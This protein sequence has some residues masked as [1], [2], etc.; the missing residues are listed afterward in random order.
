[1][2]KKAGK[3][4]QINR[5]NK[6]RRNVRN[7]KNT[8]KQKRRTNKQ[9]RKKRATRKRHGVKRGGSAAAEEPASAAAEEPA[10]AAAEEPVDYMIPS[11]RLVLPV[12][13]IEGPIGEEEL[14]LDRAADYISKNEPGM[15]ALCFLQFTDIVKPN[16]IYRDVA[17]LLDV[18]TSAL[19]VFNQRKVVNAKGNI[20]ASKPKQT[21]L[22]ELQNSD[23]R[24]TQIDEGKQLWQV[25]IDKYLQQFYDVHKVLH[26]AARSYSELEN[27][28]AINTR[29]NNFLFPSSIDGSTKIAKDILK[30]IYHLL[31]QQELAQTEKNQHFKFAL[32]NRIHNRILAIFD[33]ISRIVNT[34]AEHD[35]TIVMTVI[36]YLLN[37][38]FIVKVLAKDENIF[39]EGI[40][41]PPTFSLSRLWGG[42]P[43]IEPSVVQNIIPLNRLVLRERALVKLPSFTELMKTKLWFIIEMIPEQRTTILEWIKDYHD[44]NQLS[45]NFH[46]LLSTI[47]H[48]FINVI[49][50]I[51]NP[52]TLMGTI[53]LFVGIFE[54][55]HRDF[56][57]IIKNPIATGRVIYNIPREL[58]N[59][60]QSLNDLLSRQFNQQSELLKEKFEKYIQKII[61]Q[62]LYVHYIINGNCSKMFIGN[63]STIVSAG[64]IERIDQISAKF[65][66]DGTMEWVDETL[67]ELKLNQAKIGQA[68]DKRLFSMLGKTQDETRERM[69][70]Y[71][72]LGNSRYKTN[73]QDVA[74]GL[75]NPNNRGLFDKKEAKLQKNARKRAEKEAN[76]QKAAENIAR[77]LKEGVPQ[78]NQ[79]SEF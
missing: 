34:I 24:W 21:F 71:K 36:D 51:K 54:I 28:E 68:G 22:K 58:N 4:T 70:H 62:M 76:K 10:S 14:L 67:A 1:M 66:E 31:L 6:T 32:F 40:E 12:A 18:G 39:I 17:K 74:W 61:N 29:L 79:S 25:D 7:R 65:Q 55:L 49:P 16:P 56:K 11:R 44:S 5:S 57:N 13:C 9:N 72:F 43:H 35:P 23:R 27:L 73:P 8:K 38:E 47:S 2:A 33:D 20:P 50:D 78:T 64:G 45:S 69:N 19:T 53:N 30:I 48:F 59:E 15:A 60:L 46:P 42:L 77:L 75:G 63:Q 37:Q 52:V 3:K 41:K 26:E